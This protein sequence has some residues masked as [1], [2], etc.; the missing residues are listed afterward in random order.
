[1]TPL[2][3]IAE[4]NLIGFYG[5][6]NRGYGHGVPVV[7][8]PHRDRRRLQPRNGAAGFHPD[9]PLIH[10]KVWYGAIGF[11]GFKCSR[12]VVA[13]VSHLFQF[14]LGQGRGSGQILA[15]GRAFT[16][17]DRHACKGQDGNHKES[18]RNDGFQEGQPLMV[19][20]EAHTEISGG[21]HFYTTR[22]A[23]LDPFFSR[24]I[25]DLYR[26]KTGGRASRIEDRIPVGLDL[27]SCKLLSDRAGFDGFTGIGFSIIVVVIQNIVMVRVRKKDA[28][29]IA[30]PDGLCLRC[31]EVRANLSNHSIQAIL[32]KLRGKPDAA[33]P[34]HD[35]QN[36]KDNH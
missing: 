15:C 29:F 26:A 2:W 33:Q 10:V 9:D 4:L 14:I 13:G 1:M 27:D 7:Q 8:P 28:D 35:R 32:R 20:H 23:D 34:Q 30:L 21:G 18:H 36:P 5:R 12:R 22:Y 31:Q 19:C 17:R 3:L 24:G 6:K 11:R 16:R 25:E